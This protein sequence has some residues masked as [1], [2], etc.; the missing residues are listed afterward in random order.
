LKDWHNWVDL[1]NFFTFAVSYMAALF[2]YTTKPW[3]I[4][5]KALYDSPGFRIGC[6]VL[7]IV[8][9]LKF[10]YIVRVFIGL[11]KIVEF[12][13]KVF[14]RSYQFL[15][16]LLIWMTTQTV[17]VMITGTDLVHNEVETMALCEKLSNSSYPEGCAPNPSISATGY[18]QSV[19]KPEYINIGRAMTYFLQNFQSSIGNSIPPMHLQWDSMV[20]SGDPSKARWGYFMTYLVWI[21]FFL[22]TVLNMIILLNFLITIISQTY[23]EVYGR[24]QIDDFKN[25]SQLNHE[26]RLVLKIFHRAL[27]KYP[28]RVLKM[29]IKAVIY[30]FIIGPLYI[31]YICLLKLFCV[32]GN[33]F[34]GI[35][36]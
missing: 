1:I 15:L 35:G 34:K 5:H 10:H 16:Y 13:Q 24:D 2:W 3:H 9:M 29:I 7:M 11:G 20:E 4:D 8:M 14:A 23:E 19:E 17:V 6:F 28:I 12:V 32:Q 27:T 31:V 30:I 22:I 36:E 33:H 25:M 26:S 18:Y 21:I